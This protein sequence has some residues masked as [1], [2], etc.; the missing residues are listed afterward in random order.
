MPAASFRIALVLSLIAFARPAAAQAPVSDLVEQWRGEG[1][2]FPWVSTLPE[3]AGRTVQV[4]YTC[5]GDAQ[6]P[7]IVMVHGFPT[8]SFDFRLPARELSVDYRVCMLDFPGARLLIS[9]D[10]KLF[11]LPSLS[12]EPRQ[13]LPRP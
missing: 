8:S 2:Y 7:A 11:I 3:N 10:R 6:K 12:A 1:R 5:H 4:F 9:V 13:L